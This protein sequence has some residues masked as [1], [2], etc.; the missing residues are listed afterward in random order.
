[1]GRSTAWRR[2]NEAMNRA[3]ISGTPA[4]PKGLRHAFGVM[5]IQN[6]IALNM[7]QKWL[8]LIEQEEQDIAARMLG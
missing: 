8:D 2:I 4:N 6:G 1:M 7:V 3:G 5:A